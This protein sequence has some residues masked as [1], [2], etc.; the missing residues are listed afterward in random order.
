MKRKITFLIS[1]FFIIL[2]TIPVIAT[3]ADEKFESERLSDHA[4]SK[5][6]SGVK[7]Y[8]FETHWKRKKV[9]GKV[10]DDIRQCVPWETNSMTG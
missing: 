10:V 9:N 8:Y 6:V 3:A 2:F 7:Y 4:A 5:N 1:I